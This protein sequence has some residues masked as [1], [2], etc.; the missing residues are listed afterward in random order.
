MSTESRKVGEGIS[1]LGIGPWCNCLYLNL[2]KS[3][4]P[5]IEF[6]PLAS[7]KFRS[8]EYEKGD[9]AEMEWHC[10]VTFYEEL[11]HWNDTITVKVGADY[12]HL[13]DDHLTHN[14]NGESIL[15][16]DGDRIAKEFIELVNRKIAGLDK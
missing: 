10:G 16:T 4:W 14:D 11:K 2:R 1:S 6:P 3:D 15:L 12:Q 8:H 9:L 5:M 7:D 13:Y